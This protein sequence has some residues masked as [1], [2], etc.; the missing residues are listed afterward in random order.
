LTN[1]RREGASLAGLSQN[2]GSFTRRRG[3]STEVSESLTH[4]KQTGCYSQPVTSTQLLVETTLELLL[5]K[6]GPP[7]VLPPT[8]P[9]KSSN[10]DRTRLNKYWP[11]VKFLQLIIAYKRMLFGSIGSTK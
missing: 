7:K 9:L 10:K 2:H 8:W 4:L 3:H 6:A 5:N 1:R 11:V